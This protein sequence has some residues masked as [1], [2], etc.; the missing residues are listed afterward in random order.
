MKTN[1]QL[2]FIPWLYLADVDG[3]GSEEFIRIKDNLLHIYRADAA[4]T[5]VLSHAF[6]VP[7]QSL[8]FGNF[9]KEGREHG[10]DQIL[11]RLTSGM[12][13][14]FAISDD[15]QSL[16]W[17][18]SQLDFISK[19]A[20][21]LVGDFDNDGTDEILTVD[22]LTNTIRLFARGASG[23][24]EERTDFMPGNLSS[25]T[26]NT[27]LLAFGLGGYRK[28]LLTV[29][30]HSGEIKF[31][32]PAL[33]N[34]KLT[35]WWGYT[36]TLDLKPGDQALA[37]NIRGA[38]TVGVAPDK[39]RID[40]Y[41]DS[42]LLRKHDTG[43]FE[44][45]EITFD[46]TTGL[47][48]HRGSTPGDLPVI[49]GPAHLFAARLQARDQLEATSRFRHDLLFVD[50]QRPEFIRLDAAFE[51]NKFHKPTFRRVYASARLHDLQHQP[52]STS[53]PSVVTQLSQE[54]W[55]NWHRNITKDVMVV[56]P[57]TVPEVV[58]ALL[59]AR[60]H[61]LKIGIVGSGW[62]Y[63]DCVVSSSTQLVINTD[64]LNRVLTDILPTILRAGVQTEDNQ[65]VLVEAGIKIYD[66]NVKLA[67]LAPA[68]AMKVLGGSRG[69]SLAGAISTSVHGGNFCE[70]PI[71]DFVRAI[72]L[73]DARGQEYWIEPESKRISEPGNFSSLLSKGKLCANI[74]LVYDDNLFRAC[75]VSMGAFGVMYSVVVETTAAFRLKKK[76]TGAG[77]N[78]TQ[79][80]I[81]SLPELSRKRELA[82]LEIVINPAGRNC[83]ITTYEETDQPIPV[84]TESPS[85]THHQDVVTAALIGT[86]FASGA[87][88]PLLGLF[89]GNI[90][91]YIA[92][93]TAEIPLEVA[94][95]NDIVDFFVK[96]LPGVIEV[97]IAKRIRRK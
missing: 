59:H 26:A 28:G 62:S 15:K 5:P 56:R 34:G 87:P 58:E 96:P 42:L 10:K 68:R 94:K 20:D 82:H 39:P 41:P 25:Q 61:Q 70:P 46:S 43:A 51:S 71:A 50:P 79:A 16:W 49:A 77:W 69:Q 6:D 78:D 88:V 23:L 4:A 32:G 53:T 21:Y 93:R 45:Y 91:F 74:K 9:V 55:Q 83:R 37:L 38:Q 13:H 72:H 73:V 52:C 65:F 22:S 81:R 67:K 3:D 14:G 57:T 2:Q 64:G 24:I 75:L 40:V 60:Q 47:A 76:T 44:W 63:T 84:P 1:S 7:I 90:G 36:A 85:S 92:R 89:L 95:P 97:Q 27:Q 12:L 18:F 86:F 11:V 30:Y 35:F 80:L 66:L 33:D 19:D 17:W 54:V 31:F 48:P 29:N 8:V